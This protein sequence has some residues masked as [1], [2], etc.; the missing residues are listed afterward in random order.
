MKWHRR[1][2]V[3]VGY[4]AAECEAVKAALS[5]AGIEYE[6]KNRSQ[7]GRWTGIAK[8]TSRSAN[9]RAGSYDKQ[10]IIYVDEDDFE[11]AEYYCDKIRHGR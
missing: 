11:S 1:R 2:E 10:Y 5:D 9:N 6:I 7:S 8:S 4:D 3:Y